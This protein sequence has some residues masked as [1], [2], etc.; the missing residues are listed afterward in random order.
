MHTLKVP[1]LGFASLF[2]LLTLIYRGSSVPLQETDDG[3]LRFVEDRLGRFGFGLHWPNF[4]CGACKAIFTVVEL[5][6][7]VREPFSNYVLVIRNVVTDMQ[8]LLRSH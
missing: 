5:A 2:L 3:Q 7:L 8:Q 6:L 1:L 4:T